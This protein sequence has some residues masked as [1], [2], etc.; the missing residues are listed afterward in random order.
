M[1]KTK[2]H[3]SSSVFKLL[4]NLKGRVRLKQRQKEIAH[5][6]IALQRPGLG[7]PR[8]R[9]S[10][11]VHHVASRDRNDEPAISQGAC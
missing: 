10:N 11:Q 2:L 8:A 3:G 1:A 9:S 5:L 4:F 6:L 7:Q